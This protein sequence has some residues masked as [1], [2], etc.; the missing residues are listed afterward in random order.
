M[1]KVG[2]LG[3]H[4]RLP[5]PGRDG[6]QVALRDQFLA[7]LPAHR[8]QDAA[9]L[10]DP[11]LVPLAARR[12]RL[13]DRQRAVVLAVDVDQIER[14]ADLP[15]QDDVPACVVQ[16]GPA[17]VLDEEILSLARLELRVGIAHVLALLPDDVARPGREVEAQD[18]KALVPQIGRVDKVALVRRQRAHGA[19]LRPAL[20]VPAPLFEGRE[21]RAHDVV[22]RAARLVD[23]PER[24]VVG[25][26]GKPPHPG[27]GFGDLGDQPPLEIV[28]PEVCR[29]HRVVMADEHDVAGGGVHV[30]H[31]AVDI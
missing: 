16:D 31:L 11:G 24:R 27:A 10:A 21:I 7:R 5:L 1:V 8:E 29:A 3:D 9:R 28:P 12:V 19:R 17:V 2:A 20:V 13:A 14:C 6:H 30:G 25:R 26:H 4:A 22:G 15:H 18:A 23:V